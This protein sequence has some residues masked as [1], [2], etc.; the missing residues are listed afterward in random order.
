MNF[1]FKSIIFFIIK[2]IFIFIL[3]NKVCDGIINCKH[4]NDDI[5]LSRYVTVT[6]IFSYLCLMNYVYTRIYKKVM[7]KIHRFHFS[8]NKILILFLSISVS[9]FYGRISKVFRKSQYVKYCL[10]FFSFQLYPFLLLV[11]YIGKESKYFYATDIL[12]KGN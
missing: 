5:F 9:F 6:K 7:I 11:F 4:G 1:M 12:L 10:S 8:F 2:N 3:I